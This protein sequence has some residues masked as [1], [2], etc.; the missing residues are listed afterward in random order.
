M[1]IV[2][3]A[4]GITQTEFQDKQIPAG[5]RVQFVTTI[6]EAKSD[7]DAY[8]YLLEENDLVKDIEQI[9]NTGAPVFVHAVSTTLKDLPGNCIRIC[10]W[11]GFLLQDTI[12]IC[13]HESNIEPAT[14]ILNVLRWHFQQVPDIVGMIA[15][16]TT[17]LI[18]NEA[19][20]I[21]ND[22]PSQKQQI[23]TAIKLAANFSSGP[24]ELAEKI[25]LLKIFNLLEHLT[26]ADRRYSPAPF[27]QK[28][29]T[30]LGASS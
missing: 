17:A 9:K 23:D 16:R 19:Y 24:F 8:F 29:I 26:A 3:I 1:Q 5:V 15:P 14:K 27:L 21:V 10:G 4:D 25:G 18:I 22:D 12:E 6:D 28:E 7:A 11:N 20:L 30:D 2:V 13:T